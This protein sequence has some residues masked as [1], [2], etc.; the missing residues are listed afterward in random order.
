LNSRA[1]ELLEGQQPA[2]PSAAQLFNKPYEPCGLPAD[3]LA[4]SE[5]R[6]A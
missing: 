3:M 2:S 4:S 5:I 1:K 6:R